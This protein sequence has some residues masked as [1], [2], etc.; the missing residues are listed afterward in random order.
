VTLHVKD[1]PKEFPSVRALWRR[2]E[3]I[4]RRDLN[5]LALAHEDYSV[6][7]FAREAHLVGRGLSVRAPRA[8][9]DKQTARLGR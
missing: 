5:N 9:R 8:I 1:V 4:G 6:G 3:S 7:H 2:K